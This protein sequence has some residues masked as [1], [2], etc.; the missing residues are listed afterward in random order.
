MMNALGWKLRSSGGKA[1]ELW[2]AGLRARA[3][4]EL[5]DGFIQRLAVLVGERSLD[6]IA[7]QD[8]TIA[9]IAQARKHSHELIELGPSAFERLAVTLHQAS[10]ASHLQ[11]ERI[12]GG[13]GLGHEVEPGRKGRLLAGESK[14]A[15]A[16]R[17]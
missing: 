12:I 14:R 16:Q 6:Q 9:S 5:G 10:H 8:R 1:P 7:N 15:A 4:A 13:C 2:D 3:V 11:C 17:L